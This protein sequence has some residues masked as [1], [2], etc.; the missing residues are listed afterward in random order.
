MIIPVDRKEVAEEMTIAELPYIKFMNAV[1]NRIVCNMVR[2]S[3]FSVVQEENGQGDE[4]FPRVGAKKE[5]VILRTSQHGM[6]FVLYQAFV[7]QEQSKA[8]LCFSMTIDEDKISV[9]QVSEVPILL[10]SLHGLYCMVCGLLLEAKSPNVM[11][12]RINGVLSAELK[13]AVLVLEN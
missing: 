13:A 7:K 10:N 1:L 12:E 4:Y 11:L 3:A 5:S 9:T 6:Q 8:T 2:D